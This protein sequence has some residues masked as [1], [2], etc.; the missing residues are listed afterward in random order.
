MW[1]RVRLDI[2]WYD[3]LAGLIGSLSYRDR[4]VYRRKLESIIPHPGAGIIACLSVRSG[5][6]LLFSALQLPPGSEIIY[7][8]VTIPDMVSVARAHQLTPVPV[9][10]RNEDFQVD[11]DVLIRAITP[12]S[13]MVL[14]AQL[15]GARLDM[16]PVIEIASE[17]GLLVAEDC[18]QGW[19]GRNEV[20][21]PDV[22]ITFYS[23]GAIKTATALGGALIHV[24][25]PDC[26]MTMRNFLATYPLQNQR[27]YRRKIM[28]YAVLKLISSR[29]GFRLLFY[30]GKMRGMSVGAILRKMTLGF[31]SHNLLLQLRKQPCT[32]LLNLMCRRILN[33]DRKR[34]DRRIVNAQRIVE[35]L[36]LHQ[37]PVHASCSEHSYWLFPYQTKTPGPLM[38]RLSQHQFDTAQYGSL[39]VVH[40]PEDRPEQECVR[41]RKRMDATVFLP[42]YSEIPISAVDRMCDVILEAETGIRE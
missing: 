24:R 18:A 25:E 19:T 29:I 28:K 14:V 32:G 36:G 30:W 35:R 1:S 11:T 12:R 37:S 27:R 8:A 16:S 17:K 3:L 22:D 6:D 7:S 13:K 10:I 39:S 42:I 20:V 33:Y 40:P 38:E 5:L 21:N 23:F 9:D 26:L 34:M 4:E 31:T 2:G 41:A 15:F